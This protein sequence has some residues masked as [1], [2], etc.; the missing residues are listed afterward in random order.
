MLPG[1]GAPYQEFLELFRD[2][3]L[4]TLASGTTCACL[5]DERNLRE[6]LIADETARWLRKAGHPVVFFLIDDSMDPLNFRQLRVAVNK[7][8]ELI[9]RYQHW[10]GKPIA[11]L[12]DPWDCCESYA[13]HVE[14]ELLSRLHCLGCHPTLIRTASLYDRGV[15][16]PYVRLVLERQEEIVKFLS[17]YFPDYHPEKLF[18]PLCPHC[19][20][21]DATRIESVKKNQVDIYCERCEHATNVPVRELRGKLNWKLDCAVRWSLF[22]VDAEPFSKSYLEPQNGSFYIAQALSHQF[23]DGRPVF[24]LQYGL[25]KMDKK[26]SYKLLESLPGGALRMML[27]ERPATDINIT[28]DLIVTI[29][30]RYEVLPK[31]SYLDFVKQLLPMWLLTPEVLT[32][33]QRELVTHGIPFGKH[34]LDTE[35][36]LHLPARQHFEKEQP[37]VLKGLHSVISQVLLLRQVVGDSWE[38]FNTGVQE[39][40]NAL[41]PQKKRVLHRLRLLVGQQQGLPAARFLFLL[42][43]DYLQM[44]EYL[45]ELRL[46]TERGTPATSPLTSPLLERI[47][48]AQ[49]TRVTEARSQLIAPSPN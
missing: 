27:V 8:P 40:F 11:H 45:L 17:R 34:F 29:A 4:V 33:A 18:W 41:G 13:A 23:F 47:S 32:P 36:R 15:Y 20:Y 43:T 1:A 25:V 12:P 31:L 48:S 14:E 49:E 37:D 39:C 3:N 22:K 10:C 16:A 2:Q 7:D 38:Q 44:L 46:K 6:F 30:S 26:F 24:P 28:R 35:V 42:P 21:I 9:E 5:G 19:D